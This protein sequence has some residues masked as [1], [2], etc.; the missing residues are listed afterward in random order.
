MVGAYTH[1]RTNDVPIQILLSVCPVSPKRDV[2]QQEEALS[3]TTWETHLPIVKYYIFQE[4]SAK[5]T[6][7]DQ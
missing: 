3:A 4:R 2:E 5:T 7:Y 6:P 1:H